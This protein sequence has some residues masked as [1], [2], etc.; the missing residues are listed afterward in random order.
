MQV[1]EGECFQQTEVVEVEMALESVT[2]TLNS[3]ILIPRIS[4]KKYR[5]SSL[6]FIVIGGT[7]GTANTGL[8][9][10]GGGGGGGE[11]NVNSEDSILCSMTLIV[12]MELDDG[13]GPS[14]SLLL[15]RII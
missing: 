9:S 15:E 10:L 13:E 12:T 5:T 4:K 6:V 11:N 2:I 1:E 8:S 14:G 3:Y 7:I